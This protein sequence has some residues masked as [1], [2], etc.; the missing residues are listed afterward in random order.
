MLNVVTYFQAHF[1]IIQFSSGSKLA[2]FHVGPI[3]IQRLSEKMA[4]QAKV[5]RE[6]IKKG[7][8]KTKEREGRKSAV[9]NNFYEVV[10][11]DDTSAG[12]V[13]CKSCEGVYVHDSHKTGTSNMVHHKCAKA[14]TS[15][16]LMTSFVRRDP[17]RVPQDVKSNLTP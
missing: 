4:A 15:T 8:L 3:C 2:S 7:E 6:K 5:V 9:W 11:P 12:Y 16:S 17:N 13:I 1:E 10:N 14:Q